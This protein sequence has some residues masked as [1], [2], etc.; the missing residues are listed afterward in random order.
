MPPGV[1]DWHATF[2]LPAVPLVTPNAT[3]PSPWCA[4]IGRVGN[5]TSSWNG[6][7]SRR[8]LQD[9]ALAGAS[10]EQVPTAYVPSTASPGAFKQARCCCR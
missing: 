2:H 7:V 4:G 8:L 10:L 9:G 6:T 1:A 3:N 5:S